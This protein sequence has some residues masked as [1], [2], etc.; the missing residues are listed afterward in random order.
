MKAGKIARRFILMFIIISQ[1]LSADAP[2]SA[3]LVEEA[4]QAWNTNEQKIVEQKFQEAI[5]ADPTN[6]RAYLGLAY[7]YEMQYKFQEA[8]K[9]YA[10]VTR[11]EKESEPYIFAAMMTQKLVISEENNASGVIALFE[12]L[13]KNARYTTMKVNAN[14]K[15]GRYYNEHAD[16]K[17][18]LFYYDQVDA[19]TDWMLIGPFDNISASGF[20]KIY[21]PEETFDTTKV[22]S[23]KNDIAIKWLNIPDL[24]YDKWVDLR[25][26]YPDDD[27]FF[28]GNTFIY[29]PEKQ[30]V[31][32][33]IGTS[34]AL[35]VFLNDE[36]MI[37]CF[38]ENNNGHDTYSVETVLQAGWN[39]LLIKCGYSE[40][41]QCNF[42]ARLTDPQGEPVANLKFSAAP[43]S[44]HSK[45]GADKKNIPNFAEEFFKEKIAA[46]P[47]HLENY[48]LLAECYAL[49]DKAIESELILREALR[50]APNNAMIYLHLVETYLRGE[51]YDEVNT[52]YEKIYQLDSDIPAVLERR[53]ADYLEK[54]NFDEAGA[55][56]ERL[57]RL[58]PESPN[59]QQNYLKYYSKRGLTDKIIETT[60]QAYARFP[61]VW[62]IV[63]TKAM[64]DSY[65][66][67]DHKEGLPILRKYIKKHTEQAAFLKLAEY[68]QKASDFKGWEK[69]NR[70]ALKFYPAAP[71]LLYQMARHYYTVHQFTLALSCITEALQLCPQCAV[72]WGTCAEIERS[73]GQKA[74]AIK[75]YERALEL[76]PTYYEARDK[77][78]QL[79]D[80][81][82]I[83]TNF[84]KANI[85]SLLKNAPSDDRYPGEKAV[86][87]YNY[88]QRAV[89]PGG[90]TEQSQEILVRVINADGIDEFKEY[91]IGYNGYN[92]ELIVEKM[93]T[94]KKDGSKIDADVSQNHVV[95]KSLEPGD[96]VY[97]KWKIRNYYAGKLSQHFWDEVN[98]N[99]FY[100]VREIGYSLLVPPEA[101]F[102]Y[103]GQ[104]MSSEP[105]SVKTT[106]DGVLYEWRLTDEP[107]VKEEANMPGLADVGKYLRISSIPD[108]DYIINWYLDLSET[109]TRS[110]YEI[111]AFL[112]TIAPDTITMSDREKIERIYKFITEEIRYSSV[113]FRQSS[114]VPQKARDVFVNRIGDCKD[115]AALG[116]AM[117]RAVGVEAHFVLVNTRDEGLNRAILPAIAFNHA[118]VA[119]QTDKEVVYL[120]LTAQN[121]PVGSVPIIDQ[122]AY[123]LEIRKGAR[124][125]YLD[126]K[127]F[128]SKVRTRSA[129][130]EI[131]TDNGII[132]HIRTIRKGAQTADIREIY[133]YKNE[134]D[135][136]REL[137]ES[138]SQDYPNVELI[139]F[140]FPD[141][142]SIVPV[143]CYEYSFKVPNYLS[144]SGS[145]L[146]FPIPWTDNFF[147]I[148]A[149]SYEQRHYPFTYWPN[150]DTIREEIE[151][152]FPAGY[153]LLDFTPLYAYSSPIADYTLQ[154]KAETGILK[155]T[156]QIINKQME[157]APEDYQVFKDF[158]NNVI[159][160][161]R[162]QILFQKE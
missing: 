69:A 110:S 97:L 81:K 162:N 92:E 152:H 120:D 80:R 89:Y 35:K 133:R 40:I 99:L 131:Q 124:P 24:R 32:L 75:S 127:Y 115:K 8:W 18:A 49:N 4:W 146:I 148:K 48:L 38:D 147:P 46:D 64:I 155:G 112:K 72:Y 95:F 6:T 84:R 125:F 76:K 26:Y 20:D 47:A 130:I 30:T 55:L 11:T 135:R 77:L 109:K 61:E 123:A 7:L 13:S 58:I 91:W 2:T 22:Y 62:D 66:K 52:A 138:L 53:F 21:P 74:A 43:Q 57:A 106:P 79:Q 14:E 1:A 159:K 85:D 113:P 54:K 160:A 161:D 28:Y 121:F 41:T 90:A 45:P 42:A 56:L 5:K 34:G 129:R 98:F 151:I 50:L 87:L 83:F 150:V 36:L 23:G 94:L 104:N 103:K 29:S 19:I 68:C 67:Q 139:S 137:T 37:E 10:N 3:R 118:L 149:L 15:L 25:R 142:D 88:R 111:N 122:E 136:S 31:H 44:Y 86:V 96:A 153:R 100:P 51:K 128:L 158:Y 16:L 39:R 59:L 9:S 144:E 108:W 60:N 105:V 132:A 63:E 119:A 102:Q 157:V 126:N 78:R 116:I 33:R 73:G 156:R 145:M 117:L 65:V 71:G 143:Q 82:S 134:T 101:V 12:N 27:A 141:I 154:L 140:E 17:K 114:L 70:Q 107:A 93:Q